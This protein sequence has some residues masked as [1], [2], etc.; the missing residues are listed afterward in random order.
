M[1]PDGRVEG[2]KEDDL[3]ETLEWDAEVLERLRS[4]KSGRSRA[5]LLDT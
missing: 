1:T 3:V 5:N 2:K 4:A